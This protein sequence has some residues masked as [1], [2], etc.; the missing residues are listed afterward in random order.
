MVYEKLTGSWKVVKIVFKGFSAVIEME[1]RKT[2]TR[3]VSMASLKPLC[4]RPS[5][6]RHPMEDEF[7]QIAWGTD[8]GLRG[9]SAAAAPMYTLMDRRT[10]V[11]TSGVARWEYR[12]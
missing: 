6:L 10:I 2:R 4:R 7:A 5:D 3:T 1:R 9:D 12:G 11:S 8:F